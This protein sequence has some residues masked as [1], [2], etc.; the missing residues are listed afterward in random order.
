MPVTRSTQYILFW[1]IAETLPP[2][3]EEHLTQQSE[4]AHGAY[5]IPVPFPRDMTL[6][7]RIELEGEGYEPVRHLNTGVDEDEMLYESYLLPVEEA[8]D[9]L[10]GTV[11]ADVVARG[12]E[13]I[14]ARREMEEGEVST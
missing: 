6:K 8:V 5:Q 12:W 9:K 4:R 11:M 7:K 3:L 2:D 13:G 10:R 1:Y 14:C